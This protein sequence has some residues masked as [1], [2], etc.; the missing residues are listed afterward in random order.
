M[1]VVRKVSGWDLN[2]ILDEY[3]SYAE[4]KVRE[5]DIKYITGFQLIEISNLFR[6]PGWQHRTRNFLKATLFAFVVLAIWLFSGSRM[7]E[8]P[9]RKLIK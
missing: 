1:G 8:G 9:K 6:N 7:V 3:R 5:C 2:N 4:P